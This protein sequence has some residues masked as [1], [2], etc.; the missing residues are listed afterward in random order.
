MMALMLVGLVMALGCF[1]WALELITRAVGSDTSWFPTDEEPWDGEEPSWHDARDDGPAAG[2]REMNARYAFGYDD[3]GVRDA[4]F[5]EVYTRSGLLDVDTVPDGWLITGILNALIV[6]LMIVRDTPL[7]QPHRPTSVLLYGPPGVARTALAH[8]IARR[9]GVGLVR[10]L[11]SQVVPRR[12]SG[13]QALVASAVNAARTDPP[14]VVF[15]DELETLVLRPQDTRRQRAVHDL[16]GGIL[17]P[18]YTPAPLLIASVTT[19]DAVPCGERLLPHPFDQTVR[20]DVPAFERAML[21]RIRT[22][23]YGTAA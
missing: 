13:S 21:N 8:A 17:Q 16:I 11:A 22:A 4:V 20:V 14:R 9:L 10:V 6:D 18:S 15:V 12:A 7:P 19:Y 3:G 2:S 1:I 23:S 5:A